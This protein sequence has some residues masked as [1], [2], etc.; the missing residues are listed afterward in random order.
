MSSNEKKTMSLAVPPHGLIEHL[1]SMT[2]A[3]NHSSARWTVANWIV[4]Q[5]REQGG[6]FLDADYRKAM[7][8]YCVF[9]AIATIHAELGFIPYELNKLRYRRTEEM[10]EFIEKSNPE[11]ADAIRKAL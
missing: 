11:A 10:L 5:L 3:N 2:D 8:Y 6:N 7:A 9:E 1:R 4:E